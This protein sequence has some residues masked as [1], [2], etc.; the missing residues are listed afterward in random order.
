VQVPV[1]NISGEIIEQIEINDTVFG[2]PFNEAVVHQALVRQLANARVGTANTKTRGE[3][4]GSTRKIYREKGTGRARQG[5]IRA[6]HRRGGGIAFGP[7]PRSFRQAMPKKM[8][9]MALRCVL[10]SK[11]A[12]GDLRVVDKLELERPST[13]E[14]VKILDNLKVYTPALLVVEE[15]KDSVSLSA[16]N[17][18]EIKAV[19]AP[20]L[21]V[22][23]LLSYQVL[24]MTVPAIRQAENLWGGQKS[25]QGENSASV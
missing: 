22:A 4:E 16:R 8:R 10:S 25:A 15:P 9:R 6:P 3:V 18:P 21:N 17:L 5:S 7:R 24:V 14:M 19:T 20:V 1:H 13:K 12:E 23:D 11:A 2:V